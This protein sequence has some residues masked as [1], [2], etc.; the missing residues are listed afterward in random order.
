LYQ[1][2]N[3]RT[4]HVVASPLPPDHPAMQCLQAGQHVPGPTQ[5]GLLGILSSI[6]FF[7]LGLACLLV[8]RKVTCKRCGEVLNEALC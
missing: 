5:W 2:Q 6:V 4:G 3:P 1:Y 8:D 7:P